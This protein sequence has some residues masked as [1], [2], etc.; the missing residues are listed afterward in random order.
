M[1]KLGTQGVAALRLGSKAVKKAYLGDAL[2]FGTEAKPP[3]LPEGYVEVEYIQSSE[4]CCIDTLCKPTTTSV[5]CTLKI[6]MDVEPQSSV[7][8]GTLYHSYRIYNKNYSYYSC[9]YTST[10]IFAYLGTY[11]STDVQSKTI[12]TNPVSRRM[13]VSCDA[14]NMT[15]AVDDNVVT[16]PNN[17]VNTTSSSV[18]LLGTGSSSYLV[19]K[20]YSCKME[21]NGAL[22]RDFVPCTDPSGAVGLY[23]LVEGKFYANSGTGELI[24]GPAV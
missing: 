19:A 11:P 1:L 4:Y 2:V 6:K 21:D 12:E 18:K 13:I 15:A 7:G 10:R 22:V 5:Y 16:F 17:V 8:N 23:D 9:F 14:A 3:R 24:A 20:L